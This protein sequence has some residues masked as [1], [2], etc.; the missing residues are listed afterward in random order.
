M[1]VATMTR[2]QFYA[3]PHVAGPV[4]CDS[5][6]ILPG[7]AEEELHDSGFRLLD[8][9]AVCDLKPIGR[10]S[11]CSDVLH[12]DGIGGY[13]RLSG[14]LPTCVPPKGWSIDCLPESGLL[15]LFAGTKIV[16]DA[17]AVSSYSIY[18]EPHDA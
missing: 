1:N 18:G 6:V 9:V 2:E 5:I 13:G 16:T 7:K 14:P 17:V 15:R 4:S 11:G 10:L 3:L 12:I 8:F